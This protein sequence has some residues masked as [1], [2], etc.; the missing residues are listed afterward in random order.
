MMAI[1]GTFFCPSICADLAG[2][3]TLASIPQHSF[4]IAALH[5]EGDIRSLVGCHLKETLHC[6]QVTWVVFWFNT[7]YAPH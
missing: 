2:M 7:Y 4:C 1:W 6:Y 5:L 3:L